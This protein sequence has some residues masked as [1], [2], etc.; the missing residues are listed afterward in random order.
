MLNKK[1]ELENVEEGARARAPANVFSAPL[2]FVF[3][4]IFLRS[5]DPCP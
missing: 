1:L 3:V 2:R 5:R 4:T